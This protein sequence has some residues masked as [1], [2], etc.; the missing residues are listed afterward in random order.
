MNSEAHQSLTQ[1]DFEFA[2]GKFNSYIFQT[3]HHIV[4]EVTF[5]PSSYLFE[6]YYSF[7]D[8]TFEFSILVIE[9]PTAGTP[10]SDHLIPGTIASI[11][12]NF[13]S[14]N[15]RIVVYI[16]ET[17]DN[18]SAARSRKFSQWFNIYKG[19]AFVKIDMQMGQ[20]TDGQTFFTSMILRLDNPQMG[21]IISAFQ[22]LITINTK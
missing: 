14:E 5:K 17:S 20:D 22:S 15:Q 8:E 16:C 12:S 3:T 4:Y 11:F 21:E 6:P 13:F 1:Y 19:T 2:G 7:K 18:K 9:N 10:P